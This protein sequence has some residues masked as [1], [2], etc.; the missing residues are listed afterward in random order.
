MSITDSVS[1][2]LLQLIVLG[3]VPF[4]AYATYERRRHKHSLREIRKRAGLQFGQPRYLLYSLALTAIVVAA[5]LVWTPPLEP[6]TREGS[7]QAKFAGLGLT[8]GSIAGALLYGAVQT[9][10]TEELLFRG[11]IG[12]MISRR[13]SMIWANTAQGFIFLLPHLTILLFAPEL[14]AVLPIVFAAALLLGWLRIKSG[15]IIGPSIVHGSANV[16]MALIVSARTVA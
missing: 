4:L 9:G 3:G 8:A 7:A 14:W 6:L 12:G 5:L 15:S 10:L 1:T 16:T 13:L 11:L 2:A